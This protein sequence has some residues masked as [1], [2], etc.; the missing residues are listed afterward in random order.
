MAQSV[1]ILPLMPD[2]LGSIHDQDVATLSLRQELLHFAL[3]GAFVAAIASN[4]GLSITPE[5]GEKIAQK[6]KLKEHT[7]PGEIKNK[8][9]LLLLF[10]FFC[11]SGVYP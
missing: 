6:N 8:L 11:P 2:I 3:P 7:P 4:C 5:L 9:L 1:G 10:L